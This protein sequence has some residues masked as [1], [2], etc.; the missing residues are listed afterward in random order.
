MSKV[1]DPIASP[2]STEVPLGG[3]RRIGDLPGGPACLSPE[4]NPPAHMVYRP[5]VYEH[6]CPACGRKVV[7]PVRGAM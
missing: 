7:F 5:G 1:L 4:H 2:V 6:V 3:T